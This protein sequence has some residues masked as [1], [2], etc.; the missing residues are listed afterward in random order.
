MGK[1]NIGMIRKDFNK[2]LKTSFGGKVFSKQFKEVLDAKKNK[3]LTS[4]ESKLTT[5]DRNVLEKIARGK[6]S[7]TLNDQEVKR[8][9]KAFKKV[10]AGTEGVALSY[11]GT[12]RNAA[13]T[14]RAFQKEQAQADAP[15][16]P[17]PAEIKHQQAVHERRMNV[18][19][20]YR[21]WDI[22]KEQGGVM[23]GRFQPRSAARTSVLKRDDPRGSVTPTPDK[24]R[25]SISDERKA[26]TSAAGALDTDHD[27]HAA[28]ANESKANAPAP[29][30]ATSNPDTAIPS[31]AG[32]APDVLSDK[33]PDVSPVTEGAMRVDLPPTTVPDTTAPAPPEDES[34]SLPDAPEPSN[35]DVDSDLPLGP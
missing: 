9:I 18:Q 27:E 13:E 21:Q 24:A 28:T 5:Y 34:P 15:K 33:G 2:S 16:G 4:K 6:D 35:Q 14:F 7:H 19:R 11:H 10:G 3:F 1:Y 25:A 22:D 31:I 12:E 8:A 17:T 29:D 26:S 32:G 23:G 20:L 30:K